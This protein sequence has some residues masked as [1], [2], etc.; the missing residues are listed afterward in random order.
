MTQTLLSPPTSPEGK[1]QN[2]VRKMESFD[3]LISKFDQYRQQLKEGATV[4]DISQDIQR[5]KDERERRAE[6]A[7]R[8]EE[9]S[10]KKGNE[11][12]RSSMWNMIRGSK[13]P[14]SSSASASAKTSKSDVSV[15]AS[16]PEGSIAADIQHHPPTSSDDPDKPSKPGSEHGPG[17]WRRVSTWGSPGGKANP[18]TKA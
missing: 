1:D 7:K 5:E 15:A 18:S 9:A 10:Q 12:W 11:G 17:I 16:A 4:E 13:D 3:D 8:R 14:N 2:G 6:E